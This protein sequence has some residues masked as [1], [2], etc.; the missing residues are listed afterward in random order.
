MEPFEIEIKCIDIP[1]KRD[2][3]ILLALIII[4]KGEKYFMRRQ[5]IMNK[6][7]GLLRRL[8]MANNKMKKEMEKLLSTPRFDQS[9]R[10]VA[11]DR[12]RLRSSID[13]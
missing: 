1:L 7:R 12:N 3:R 4:L 13:H 9:N 11:R 6:K 5:K 10:S 8:R 2:S